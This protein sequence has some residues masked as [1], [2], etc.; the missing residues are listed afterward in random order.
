MRTSDKMC[1]FVVFYAVLF[2]FLGTFG[3]TSAFAGGRLYGSRPSSFA[4]ATGCGL[5]MGPQY[6]SFDPNIGRFVTAGDIKYVDFNPITLCRKAAKICESQPSG[7]HCCINACR[8]TFAG[9]EAKVAD[10]PEFLFRKCTEKC[11]RLPTTQD[12]NTGLEKS[13]TFFYTSK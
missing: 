10:G 6:Q 2:C 7:Q 12:K 11:P 1:E 8:Q 4:L 9:F 13:S 5:G 3:V